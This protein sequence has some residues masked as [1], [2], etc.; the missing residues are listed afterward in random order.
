MEMLMSLQLPWHSQVGLGCRWL[1]L[2]GYAPK[3][4]GDF[5]ALTRP[6][7]LV[8]KTRPSSTAGWYRWTCSRIEDRGRDLSL[9]PDLLSK[10]DLS[11]YVHVFYAWLHDEGNSRSEKLGL[12]FRMVTCRLSRLV[13]RV[14]LSLPRAPETF[15]TLS[16]ICSG[17]FHS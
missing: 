11:I 5:M 17:V 3:E 9:T 7:E 13:W 2:A 1:G 8:P 4:G 6:K 15:N 16:R 10:V 12:G 14:A